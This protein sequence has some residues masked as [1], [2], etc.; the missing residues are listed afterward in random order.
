MGLI[1]HQS[2]LPIIILTGFL[3]AVNT[4]TLPVCPTRAEQT[5]APDVRKLSLIEF[6]RSHHASI[7][8][9]VTGHLWIVLVVALVGRPG[10]PVISRCP[11]YEKSGAGVFA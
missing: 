11:C 8:S 4:T 6:S 7:P 10:R 3:G 1:D 2:A 9:I 5:Y